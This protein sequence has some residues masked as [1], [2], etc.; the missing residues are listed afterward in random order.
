[1]NKYATICKYNSQYV[2]VLKRLRQ[3]CNVH[4]EVIWNP[5]DVAV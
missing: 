1:M 5:L 3:E 4:L 2:I